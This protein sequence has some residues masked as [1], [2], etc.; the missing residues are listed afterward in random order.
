[1]LIIKDPDWY[2]SNQDE[3]DKV[4]TNVIFLLVA[5]Y[6]WSRNRPGLAYLFILLFIGSTL[7]HVNTNRET[8]GIDRIT[9]ILVFS[10]F[11]HMFYPSIP[12]SVYVLIGLYTVYHW[13]TTEN[14]MPFFTYQ[15]ILALVFLFLYPM[16]IITKLA[17]IVA[18]TLLTY[19][20]VLQEGKYHSI[21]H[22][23]LS[24]LA[25]FIIT[26]T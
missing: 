5:A 15:G 13:Y 12:Y 7:F 17:I 10:Y 25:M 8:L 19:I 9:M 23:S 22:I 18:Y 14:L 24:L 2:L 4:A 20:Q 3:P 1:M 11:F 16:N 26:Y 6:A 21:K